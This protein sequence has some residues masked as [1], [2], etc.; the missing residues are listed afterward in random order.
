MVVVL[1]RWGGDGDGIDKW[2][3]VVLSGGAVVEWVVVLVGV[4]M[5]M[6]VMID[7][8]ADDDTRSINSRH[9]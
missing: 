9:R 5:E 6:G 4:T 2:G 7:D 3:W 8:G 1:I